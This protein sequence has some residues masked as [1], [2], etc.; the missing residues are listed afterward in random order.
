[1]KTLNLCGKWDGCCPGK[2]LKFTGTVPGCV[3]T[4]LISAGILPKNLYF[5][6]NSAAAL[7][8][9]NED[10]EYSRT[11]FC[12]EKEKNAFLFFECLDT[13]AKVYLN[14]VLIGTADNMFIPH[15]FCIDEALKTGENIL[16]V[17]F[18]SPIKEVSSKKELPHAFTGER[19]YTRRMQCSYGWDWAERFVTCG[20][21]GICRIEFDSVPRVENAYIYT[22]NIDSLGAYLK[23]CINFKNYASGLYYNTEIL[24]PGGN[25]VYSFSAYSE[26]P[27]HT[28]DINISSPKL[29]YP[30]GYGKQPL[31]TFKIYVNGEVFSQKFGI[32]TVKII[33][34]KDKENSPEYEL[35]KFLRSTPSGKE[36]DK[37]EIFSSFSLAVNGIKIF[38]KGADHVP[39]EP[40][41]SAV[42]KEKITALLTLAKD[43]GM[44][45][46]RVWGGGIFESDYFYSEC[47]RLGIAVTQD[48]LMA[49]GTYPE[50]DGDFLN[51]LKKEAECASIRLRNH[52]CLMW[53]TGDNENAVNGSDSD[54]SFPGRASA[55]KAIAPVL[56]KNDPSRAFL[57]SSPYGGKPYAS[58]TVGTTHNT[59]FLG[60]FFDYILN[61][62]LVDI[63]NIFK[64]FSARFIAEE[65]VMGAA[66]TPSLL[67]MMTSD[68]LLKSEEMLLWH[69]KTNPCLPLHLLDYMKIFSKKLFGEFED[70]EDK[71][72]KLQYLQYEWLRLSFEQV[73]RN[74]NFC[75]GVIYWMLSDFW[76]AASGWSLIDYYLLPKAGYYS[77]KRCAKNVIGSFDEENGKPVLCICSDL[78]EE[79]TVNL[80]FRLYDS[81]SKK[82]VKSEEKTTTVFADKISKTYSPICPDRGQILLCDIEGFDRCFFIKGLPKIKKCEE[83]DFEITQSGVTVRTKESYLHAV[84]LEGEAVFD[85][86]FF[87]LLP[88]EEKTVTFRL[89]ENADIKDISI[90]AYAFR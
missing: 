80:K 31:Y 22:Q 46:I 49:C 77:F 8:I 69:T 33:R 64:E 89:F 18:R 72:F 60:T 20:I 75:S 16:T 10:F 32:R 7:W 45:M 56:Y 54:V 57:P 83:F 41:V 13:Y 9:E 81:T 30:H 55:L 36:Y 38:C 24:D 3:H 78:S 61:K 43:A 42:K 73:R 11:F 50:D 88:H 40:F 47:D 27:T 51:Q 59:Q 37:N 82:I 85:D 6:D 63:K 5:R 67:K 19:L 4:D 23:L 17:R 15:R 70:G 62:D 44:N 58:K 76:P 74:K 1:M 68:D 2:N 90:S 12:E 84:R 34:Q 53:W 48:F 52:P 87:S 29:W 28:L 65:P 79:I 71:I 21:S 35:C 26:E 25:T 14:S 86:N 39:C 66:S